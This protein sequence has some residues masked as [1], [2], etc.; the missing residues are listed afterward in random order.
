MCLFPKWI[1]RGIPLEGTQLGFAG[2]PSQVLQQQ[3]NDEEGLCVARRWVVEK[4]LPLNNEDAKYQFLC[5]SCK[6]RDVRHP[7]CL[8]TQCLHKDMD[9]LK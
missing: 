5:K 3:R 9:G 4:P 7:M 1:I 8:V 6:E 2:S